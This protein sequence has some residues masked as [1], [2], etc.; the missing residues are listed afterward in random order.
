MSL[1]FPNS[2]PPPPATPTPRWYEFIDTGLLI[3][4]RKPLLFLHVYHHSATMVLTYTQIVGTT[5]VQWVPILLNLF[6]HT[7]MYYYYALSTLGIRVW[8]KKMVTVVQIIQFVLDLVAC[9]YCTI[10]HFTWTYTPWR[11]SNCFGS[12]AAAVFGCAL[13]TSYLVLFLI[14]YRNTYKAKGAKAAA[15]VAVNGSKEAKKDE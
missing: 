13:L 1:E 11:Y 14:F 3:L 6:V 12:P 15:A 4:K 7:I 5:S 8:W 10:L 9:Y 2:L